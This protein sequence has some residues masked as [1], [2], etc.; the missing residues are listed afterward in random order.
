MTLMQKISFVL[1]LLAPLIAVLYKPL[2]LRAEVLGV[3]R[4]VDKIQNIHG[5]DFQVIDDTLYME[6]LHYHEPSGL[7]FGASEEKAETRWKWFPP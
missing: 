1:V 7:L 3:F 5:S 2:S 4:S 6:D